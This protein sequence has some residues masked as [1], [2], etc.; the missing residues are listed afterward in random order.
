MTVT[1]KICGLTEPAG[2]AA[3]VAAGAR[4]VGF[5]FFAKSPRHVSPEQA[6]DLA[7]QVPLGIAKVGLFV[8][9]DDA[10][11]RA[12]LDKVPLDMI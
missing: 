5:V 7:A 9:P 8:D 4:Y 3:A 12:V 1:V 6:A 10:L 11:L 2:L